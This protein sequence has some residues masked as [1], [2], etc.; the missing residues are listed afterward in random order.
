MIERKI[1]SIFKEL[2]TEFLNPF[3]KNIEK[4][5]SELKKSTQHISNSVDEQK[6]NLDKVVCELHQLRVENGK[7]NKR[8]EEIEVE[9]AALESQSTENERV[10]IINQAE[11]TNSSLFQTVE[12]ISEWEERKKRS[13]NIIITNIS[14]STKNDKTQRTL[15]EIDKVQLLDHNVKVFRQG[16]FDPNKIR[17]VKVIFNTEKD[18]KQVS[19]N[20]NK[21]PGS[22][23]V[24]FDQTMIQREYYKHVKDNKLKE[25]VEKGDTSKTI[26]YV[27]SVPKIVNL[28]N[29]KSLIFK[30]AMLVLLVMIN[31]LYIPMLIV[32]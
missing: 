15:D 6:T 29:K 13:K 5:F 27:N 14:E 11:A 4:E 21:L 10:R 19:F 9:I 22:V 28:K 1:K 24:F 16:K 18:A 32:F 7:L 8:I 2:L 23:K 25:M 17:L 20:K 3:K 12:A 30:I 31:I 26:K